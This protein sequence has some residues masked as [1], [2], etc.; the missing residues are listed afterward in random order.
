[1]YQDERS[2]CISRQRFTV[3][4]SF[5]FVRQSDKFGIC[6]FPSDC[7]QIRDKQREREE[8]SSMPRKTPRVQSAESPRA[9]SRIHAQRGAQ[10]VSQIE[11]PRREDSKPRAAA[12][13]SGGCVSRGGK[14]G[15]HGHEGRMRSKNFHRTHSYTRACVRARARSKTTSR[16]EKGARKREDSL[17]LARRI[18][19]K[20]IRNMRHAPSPRPVDDR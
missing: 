4:L 7:S 1:M 3:F 8:G 5:S 19:L 12:L 6:V 20:R 16:S 18:A 9:I 10:N 14:S 13:A 17:K 11:Y 2:P 15:F